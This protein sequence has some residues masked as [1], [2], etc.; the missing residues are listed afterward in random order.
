MPSTAARFVSLGVRSEVGQ[1]LRHSGFQTSGLNHMHH[2]L[3]CTSCDWDPALFEDFEADCCVVIRDVKEF[4]R[5]LEN[6]AASQLGGWY[7]HHNP[8]EYFDP[9]ERVAKQ[10]IDNAVSKDFRFAYQKEYRFLWA[11]FQGLPAEGHKSL[12]LGP[13]GDIVSLHDRPGLR[14]LVKST[15]QDLRLKTDAGFMARQRQPTRK[16]PVPTDPESYR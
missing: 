7:F 11:S 5:R 8:V 16:A 10:R 14:S 12:E 9:S 1:E 4:S 6:A 2:V 15:H 3:R 13:L